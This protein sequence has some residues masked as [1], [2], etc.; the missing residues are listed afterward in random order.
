[1]RNMTRRHDEILAIIRE[2]S[3]SVTV[4]DLADFV[5]EISRASIINIALD[6]FGSGY[7]VYDRINGR[8]AYRI[9]ARG[10][11]AA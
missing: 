1:M 5:T 4:G 2:A 10:R 11:A 3:V 6:L 8:N 9:T 7:V